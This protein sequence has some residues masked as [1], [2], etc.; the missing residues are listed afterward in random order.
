MSQRDAARAAYLVQRAEDLIRAH[1]LRHPKPSSPIKAQL[2]EPDFA[3]AEQ[4][5]SD[6]WTTRARSELLRRLGRR[7]VTGA[8]SGRDVDE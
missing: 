2:S 4:A 6:A 3:A 5:R 7:D 1:E 8:G